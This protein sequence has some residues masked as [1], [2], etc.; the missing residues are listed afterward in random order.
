M[1]RGTVLHRQDDQ[2]VSDAQVAARERD[3]FVRRRRTGGRGPALCRCFR[4]SCCRLGGTHAHF[5][6]DASRH[7][8]PLPPLRPRPATP[9]R[10]L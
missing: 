7:C 2:V 5:F 9:A 8:I 4:E 1:R 10:L 6:G 3:A